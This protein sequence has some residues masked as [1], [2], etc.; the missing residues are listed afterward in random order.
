[1]VHTL[2]HSRH[3]RKKH[4]PGIGEQQTNFE[5]EGSFEIVY[6]KTFISMD[7]SATVNHDH[8]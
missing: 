2:I 5:R 1:M 8:L 3:N 6:L 7:R 4:K